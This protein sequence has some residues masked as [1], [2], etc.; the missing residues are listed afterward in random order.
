MRTHGTELVRYKDARRNGRD[1]QPQR[2][3]SQKEKP[4]VHELRNTKKRKVIVPWVIEE[5]R[6]FGRYQN[7]RIARTVAQTE[8]RKHPGNFE[9]RLQGSREIIKP[10]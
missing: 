10:R 4:V 7:D 9:F 8:M 6:R 1:V 3:K 2:P 5:R